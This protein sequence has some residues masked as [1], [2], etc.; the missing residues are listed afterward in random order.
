MVA[1]PIGE[2]SIGDLPRL[3]LACALSPH[4]ASLENDLASVPNLVKIGSELGAD[5]PPGGLGVWRSSDRS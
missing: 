1:M 3:P 5:F 2:Q 4:T